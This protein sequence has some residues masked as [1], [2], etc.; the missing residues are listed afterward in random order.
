MIYFL[1]YWLPPVLWMAF[2][3]PLTNDTLSAQSTAHIIVPLIEPIIRLFFPDASQ[4]T[5]HTIHI[6]I[7]KLFHLLNYAFLAFLLW[8]AFQGKNK[9]WCW[10]WIL[11]ACFISIGYGALD[12]FLQTMTTTRTG[13]FSDWMIDSMG[14][15]FFLGVVTLR[16]Q[17]HEGTLS[18]KTI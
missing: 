13:S 9:N 2:L 15:L 17:N 11:Y 1:N 6:L 16:R 3:F 5:I 8:R 12:E 18:E 14:V 4:T 7:R 10:K